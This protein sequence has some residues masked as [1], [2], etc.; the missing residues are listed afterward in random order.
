[1]LVGIS[2]Q[3]GF[4]LRKK[5][6]EICG[7]DV[8]QWRPALVAKTGADGDTL[9]PSRAAAAKH[10]G[11]ALGLHARAEAMLL[12]A[13]SAVRLKCA[14]GH[15]NALLILKENLCHVGKYPVYLRLRQESSLGCCAPLSRRIGRHLGPRGEL[16]GKTIIRSCSDTVP[17]RG[18]RMRFSTNFSAFT[19]DGATEKRI[20]E[21]L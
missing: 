5:P 4:C 1:L 13:G 15:R 11:T 17:R 21:L 10:C 2:V 14:L 18:I 19:T 3:G 7:F 20:G 8:Q 16:R 6:L 12:Y 9:A